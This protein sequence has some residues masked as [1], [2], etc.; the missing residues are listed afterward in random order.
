MYFVHFQSET[1]CHFSGIVLG[2]ASRNGNFVPKYV[3]KIQK[4]PTKTIRLQVLKNQEQ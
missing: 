2:T 3:Q 4:I 1:S